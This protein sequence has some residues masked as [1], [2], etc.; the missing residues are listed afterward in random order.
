M[1]YHSESGTESETGDY[2]LSTPDQ[3]DTILHVRFPTP[4]TFPKPYLTLQEVIDNTSDQEQNANME[5]GPDEALHYIINHFNVDVVS[6]SIQRFPE[7]SFEQVYHS[8]YITTSRYQKLQKLI[9]LSAKNLQN[10]HAFAQ[11][12]L[13]IEQHVRYY[14][15][16]DTLTISF[17]M[18]IIVQILYSLPSMN[19]RSQKKEALQNPM[20][21]QFGHGDIDSRQYFFTLPN[22]IDDNSFVHLVQQ[23]TTLFDLQDLDH[24]D[25]VNHK[26]GKRR[27]AESRALKR[28]TK[29]LEKVVRLKRELIRK[30][31]LGEL[32]PVWRNQERRPKG[33]KRIKKEEPLS[34]IIKIETPPTP[35]LQYPPTPPHRYESMPLSRYQSIDL[36]NFIWSS[37]YAPSPI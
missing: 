37:R 4:Y 35:T 28:E 11:Q 25:L 12:W 26:E 15:T 9:D 10:K 34:P 1:E 2:T 18:P 8:T 6:N 31:E 32:G 27:L 7:Y 16:S 17:A 30:A 23:D 19:T 36:N 14:S 22:T 3:N 21:P 24:E 33:V 29:R 5:T 13:A 20:E